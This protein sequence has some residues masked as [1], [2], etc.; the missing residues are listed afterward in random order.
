MLCTLCRVGPKCSL[1]VC[2]GWGLSMAR[3]G[4]ACMDAFLGGQCHFLDNQISC[5][6][7]LALWVSFHFINHP[8]IPPAVCINEPSGTFTNNGTVCAGMAF[9]TYQCAPNHVNT[10]GTEPEVVACSVA[11]T[12]WA[13]LKPAMLT[14]NGKHLPEEFCIVLHSLLPF[15]TSHFLEGK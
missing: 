15:F 4:S 7:D 10:M 3:V 6:T 11:G 9:C 12:S 14:C 5:H 1:G 2:Q 13:A 8:P